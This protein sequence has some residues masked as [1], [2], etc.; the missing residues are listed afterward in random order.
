MNQFHIPQC[1]TFL[2]KLFILSSRNV[3]G[4]TNNEL[5]SSAHNLQKMATEEMKHVYK[6]L[7][8]STDLGKKD[9]R[10]DQ[11]EVARLL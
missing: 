3:S 6:L 4:L 5:T 2:P 10:D 1:S 11:E 8:S 7:H 9:I